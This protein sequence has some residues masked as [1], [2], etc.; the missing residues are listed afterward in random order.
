MKPSEM[1]IL[2]DFDGVLVDSL[3][4]HLEAWKKSYFLLF[5]QD[6]PTEILF[7]QIGKS[8]RYIASTLSQFAHKPY[9]KDQLAAKKSTLVMNHIHDVNL[10]PGTKKFL[11]LI[12]NLGMSFGIVSNASREFISKILSHHDLN[13]PFFFGIEDYTK[14][15]PDP[16]PYLMGAKKLGFSFA[17]HNRIFVFEDSIPGLKAAYFAKMTTV[18]VCTQHNAESLQA[19]GAH[20]TCHHLGEI[21]EKGGVGPLV[22]S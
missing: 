1:A 6:L 18:G 11:Q 13:V 22:L 16:S 12:Q 7:A 10:L 14:P 17:D 2:F 21:I 3:P 19:A 20:F 8:T 9:C 5:K 4:I 15:K